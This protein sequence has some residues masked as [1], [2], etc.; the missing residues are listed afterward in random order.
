MTRAVPVLVSLLSAV[1]IGAA[2]CNGGG[3]GGD[4]GPGDATTPPE[5]GPAICNEFTDAGLPCPQASPVLC[6]QQC[7]TGGCS[8]SETPAGRVWVCHTDTSCLPDCAPIDDGCTQLPTGDALT[9][10]DGSE[11]DG[12]ADAG[13]DAGAAAGT[14]APSG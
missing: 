5:D 2:G 12:S 1:A 11:P 9:P 7:T 8:C 14:D 13:A 10:D 4:G 3:S 6:F